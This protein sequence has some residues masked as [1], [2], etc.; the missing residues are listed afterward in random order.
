MGHS[1]TI[2][3]EQWPQYE[4]KYLVQDTIEMPVQ[5]LGRMRGT[6]T[7]SVNASQDEVVEI[8]KQNPEISKYLTAPIKKVI[9]V[10]KR[11]LNFII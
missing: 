7:I 11:I 4:E 1:G 3:Y 8:A 2:A 6:I 10:P 5:I 9:F